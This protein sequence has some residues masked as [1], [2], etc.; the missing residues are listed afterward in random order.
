LD[1]VL[2]TI[3]I[4]TV[5]AILAGGLPVIIDTDRRQKCSGNTTTAHKLHFVADTIIAYLCMN[6]FR[7]SAFCASDPTLHID[8]GAST[9]TTKELLCQT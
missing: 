4:P 2:Q 7:K 5:F 3:I 1:R 8:K 6:K 9:I